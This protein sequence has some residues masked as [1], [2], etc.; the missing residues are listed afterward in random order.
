MRERGLS[1]G[2]IQRGDLNNDVALGPIQE[3]AGRGSG[4]AENRLL[5]ETRWIIRGSVARRVDRSNTKRKCA[6]LTFEESSQ[7]SAHIAVPNER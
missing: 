4:R 5:R 2:R 1:V 6:A 7:S 3:F